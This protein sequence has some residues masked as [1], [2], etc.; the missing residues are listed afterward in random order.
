M[1]EPMAD[2]DFRNP[3]AINPEPRGNVVLPVASGE[4]RFDDRR[5]LFS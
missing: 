5:I 3:S 2:R 4:H 1:P